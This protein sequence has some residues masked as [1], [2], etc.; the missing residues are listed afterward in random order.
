MF[1]FTSPLRRAAVAVLL[2]AAPVVPAAD[3]NPTQ[4]RAD[5]FLAL[6]NSE[7]QAMITIEGNAQ[8]DA[9]TDVS[10]V[11]DAASEVGSKAR[12]AF[13]GNPALI[14]E[15][16]ALLLKRAELNDLTVRELE[17]LLL[18]AA[19]GPMTNP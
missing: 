18:N 6:V 10:P 17:Q 11:H 15:T 9:L 12:A 7:Y 8:W 14:N 2:A 4:E 5:R 13:L 3:A 1:T 19:E 16:K